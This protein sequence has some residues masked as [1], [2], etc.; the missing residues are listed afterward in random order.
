MNPLDDRLGPLA[1]LAGTWAGT[2]HGVYP[3]IEPFDYVEEVTFTDPVVKPFLAY[4]QRTR[5]ADDGRPL[6]SE[7]G[8]M[9]WSAGAPE[10][11]IAA[12]GGRAEV[13]LGE[14]VVFAH[15]ALD[16]GVDLTFRTLSVVL[17]P[18]AKRVDSVGRLLRVRGDVL[19]YQLH[20]AAM[21]QPYQLHLTAE[22]RRT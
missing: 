12:P 8:F 4:V 14:A 22:L 7:S 19:T 15:S 10:W 11:V 2:G 18:T 20:M 16:A 5:A 3:T 1:V 17:T 6:H 9:R 13:H 21:G